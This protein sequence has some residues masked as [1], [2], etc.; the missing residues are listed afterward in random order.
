[1]AEL[2]TC[3]TQ[4]Q[5][6]RLSIFE[7]GGHPEIQVA[8]VFGV[9]QVALQLSCVV[10]VECQH[11]IDKKM[12]WHSTS[13]LDSSARKSTS[14][15]SVNLLKVLENEAFDERQCGLSPR[16]RKLQP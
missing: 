3:S 16:K 7:R 12:C 6:G 1:M 11:I 5:T 10:S 9:A 8:A 4:N 14:L 2:M 13:M 15:P